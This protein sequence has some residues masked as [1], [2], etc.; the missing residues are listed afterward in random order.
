[1]RWEVS[2]IADVTYEPITGEWGTEGGI[3]KVLRTT[4]F[5][6]SGELDLTDIVQR[7]IDKKKIE[8]KRLVIGDIILEK[9]G[10]SPS[11]PVGR[12][13]YFDITSEETYLCNN[14]TCI[15]RAKEKI[16]SR[17]L[18]WYLFN[19]HQTKATLNYQNKTTGIIN[20]QL[21]RYL[22]ELEIPLPPLPVQERIAAILDEADA[23]RKKD[24]ALLKKYDELLQS[25]F[26]DMFGDPVK[27]DKGWEVRKL[28]D[29]A[30]K[31][32]DGTHASPKFIEKGIPFLFVSNIT[33]NKIDYN[34]AKYISQEEYEQLIKRTPIELGDILLTSVGSYGNPAIVETDKKFCFQ[35][36]IA[37]I[38][39]DR[40]L[41]NPYFLFASLM[42]QGVKRQIDRKVKGIAQ[43]TLNL[44]ELNT[45]DILCPSLSIQGNFEKVIRTIN[46]QKQTILTQQA[47]SEA[48][49]QSLMQRAFKGE[50][51]G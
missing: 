47:Q 37:Y 36:H 3:V 31:I 42:S 14:F 2:P 1:M 34:T 35:R 32:T 50:L 44:S 21:K 48:L 39:P 45:V 4:N 33:N 15:I 24:A 22:N 18:F 27:N 8:N 11:Q 16:N 13:V 49:F 20:L 19:N 51:V 10:G 25:I 12:V 6:N 7:N 40:K 29:L 28:K 41:I 5:T 17:Y 26:Y 23:L 9:S 43:K 38:K 30:I 46:T